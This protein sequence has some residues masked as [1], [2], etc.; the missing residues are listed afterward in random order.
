MNEGRLPVE[1]SENVEASANVEE[2]A[3]VQASEHVLPW[4]EI[5]A[6]AEAEL[7]RAAQDVPEVAGSRLEAIGW[8]TVD[9]ERAARE[10]GGT[11]AAAAWDVAARDDALGATA[12]LRRIGGDAP[13]ANARTPRLVLLEPDTEGRLAGFLVRHGEG[14][15]ALYIAPVEGRIEREEE[16]AGSGSGS[17]S[18]PL[19]GRV[20]GSPLGPARLVRRPDRGADILVLL[21]SAGG[22]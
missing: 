6:A 3:D 15:A 17:A 4:N 9:V 2:P 11:G 1:A 8:A 7:E 21:G 16:V 10:M 14:I 19:L 12:W 13:D 22:P 5:L 20:T 18:V